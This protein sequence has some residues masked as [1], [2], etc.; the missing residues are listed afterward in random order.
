[1]LA[2]ASDE[3]FDNRYKFQA[4]RKASFKLTVRQ[5]ADGRTIVYGV[6]CYSS[7][8][9][10]E[11]WRDVRGGELLTSENASEIS[12]AIHRVAAEL[13]ARMMDGRW[14]R[15]YWPQLA[16]ECTADLPAVEL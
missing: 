2:S 16:H 9:K 3:E 11:H 10:G 1:V 13:E 8:Y 15:G 4:N 5:H 14:S 6:H 12:C 7:E